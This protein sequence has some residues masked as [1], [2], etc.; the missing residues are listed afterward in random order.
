MPM[1]K[2]AFIN[3]TLAVWLVLLVPVIGY[4]QTKAEQDVLALSSAKFRWMTEQRFDSLK[5][6]LDERVQYIHS[7]GWIQTRT[8]FFDD[9]KTGK[10]VYESIE[11]KTASARAF[12]STVIVVGSGIFTV[13]M[14]GRT[15]TFDLSYTEVYVQ[16]AKQWTLVSRHANRNL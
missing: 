1:K 3:F 2:A 6:L 11:V 15:L 12:G 8:D 10:L 16:K 13:T 7:N 14:S 4:S 9:F 5:N